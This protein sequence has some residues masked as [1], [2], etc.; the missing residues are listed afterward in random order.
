MKKV[1][2]S[3]TAVVLVLAIAGTGTVN[4]TRTNNEALPCS[5]VDPD[6]TVCT[7]ESAIECCETDDHIIKT[8]RNKPF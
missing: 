5:I 4:A 6:S 3:L 8:E 1:K 2:L 7:N